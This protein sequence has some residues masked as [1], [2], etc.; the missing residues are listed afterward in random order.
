MRTGRHFFDPLEIGA[1]ACLY[2]YQQ[3]RFTDFHDSFV[4]IPTI[5]LQRIVDFS[6]F[7]RILG[8]KTVLI[9]NY[10]KSDMLT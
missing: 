1:H 4:L 2:T 3:L 6:T 10:A 8:K 5:L 9:Q 7:G